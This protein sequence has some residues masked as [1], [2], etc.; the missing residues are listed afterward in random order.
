VR[1]F[2]TIHWEGDLSGNCVI[3][4]QTK[5]P[6]T[7]IEIDLNTAKDVW[8]AIKVLAVR[9]APAIGVAAAYGMV[10]GLRE[11]GDSDSFL[12]DL[13]KVK[14][15][16]DSSRPTAVNLSWATAEMLETGTGFFAGNKD[17]KACREALLL[18]AREIHEDDVR[19]CDAIGENGADL[20][21]EGGV[22][23]TH[24]NAGALATAGAGTALS[25]FYAAQKQGKKFEVYADET[26]PLLQGGRLTAWELNKS[27]IDVTVICDNMAGFLMSR[28][29]VDLVVVGSDRIAANGDI[30]NK[31]GTYTL[32]LMA[33]EHGVPF[34]VAA[35]LSTFDF[36]LKEGSEIP[37][38]M[39]DRDEIALSQGKKSVGDGISVWNPAFDVT[40]AALIEGI[41][42]EE[43]ILRKGSNSDFSDSIR[44][45]Y[46]KLKGLK[47]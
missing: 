13:K 37:I 28:K 18:K 14:D 27:G 35:P 11:A 25:V 20:V 2:E 23:L 24:C 32:A 3:I 39:R 15:Y 47:I 44:E 26:R 34:Y 46:G 42:T 4:D 33:R 1:D 9:G 5:L 10:L 45:V 7:F 8:E 6:E 19:R 12:E 38:E 31:I 17:L 29:K 22:C 43:G 36:S 30:A 40:P 21:P 41:I 16:L